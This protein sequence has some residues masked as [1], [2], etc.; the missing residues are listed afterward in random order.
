MTSPTLLLAPKKARLTQNSFEAL[1]SSQAGLVA[2]LAS[3]TNITILAPNNDALSKFLNSPAG[4]AAAGNADLVTALL[5]YHVINGT[6]PASAFTNSSAFLPTLLTNE[7]FTNVT[8]GQRVGGMLN[9]T[10]VV[11]TSGL[12]S[13]SIVT[14]AVSLPFCLK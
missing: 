6:Y 11:I 13:K 2:S 14:T 8:G 4:G 12:L 3:A 9:G 1:L 7:T 5:T 10:E